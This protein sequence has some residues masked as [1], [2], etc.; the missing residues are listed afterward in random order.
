MH[1]TPEM[2]FRRPSR[3]V[4]IGRIGVG[5]DN[6]VRVQS[7]TNTDT[8]DAEATLAQIAALSDAGCEIVR[9]AVLDEAAAKALC[10]IRAG[11]DVP[12]VADIHFD[13]RLAV[14]ALEAGM[15][16]LRINPGNIG[17]EAA[18]DTVVAAATAHSAP[19]RI[20]V[21]SGSVQKDLLKKYGGPTP[22]AMVESALTHIAYLEK[23][24]FYDIKVSLKSSSV[25]RTIA[26]YRLLAR[27]VDYPLHIGV[28]EAGTPLRGAVKSAVGLGILLA[29]GL[30][31]TLR[32]SLT[33]DPVTEIG[34][35]YE[36]LRALDLRARGPEIISCPTCGR[37]EIDLV[38]LAEAVEARLRHV[39]DVFTVA[40]M[41][42]VV[43]GP[44]EAREADIGIAGGRD[45]GII[46]RKGEVLGKV[47]GAE[48]L[49][50]AFMDELERY[51]TE[52]KESAC[53]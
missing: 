10:A 9:L 26:A 2:P 23:R 30:G 35:A 39:P 8:R 11:T 41:G 17:S 28:T 50:P 1:T 46:F 21:N 19:I 37:T 45:C 40:V 53:D 38:G 33:G 12:L 13:H 27:Q 15:D 14:A 47:R 52:K 31:D 42:C 4:A 25:T 24:G 5:G 32:V 29:E 44:G 49:I 36:I 16:A 34:V 20:G 6:P 3:T 7:M 48:N 51:L 43:N 18:V 22:E